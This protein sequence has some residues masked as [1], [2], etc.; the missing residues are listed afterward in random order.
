MPPMRRTDHLRTRLTLPRHLTDAPLT[1]STHDPLDGL[2][3]AKRRQGARALARTHLPVL[4]GSHDPPS[5]LARQARTASYSASIER[6]LTRYSTH[7]GV[8]V[9]ALN[10]AL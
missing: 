9:Y 5:E 7:A 3:T 6:C 1:G 10:A 8:Y 4:T 2:H